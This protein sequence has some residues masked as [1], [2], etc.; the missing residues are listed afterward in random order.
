MAAEPPWTAQD[1]R[2]MT[3]ALE[4]AQSAYDIGEVPVGALVVSAQGDILGQGY[5]RTIIDH[6]PTAHAEIVA[7]RSAA[8]ALENYRL[9][10]ITVYVTLEPCVMCI[11]AMLH[12]L[13]LIHI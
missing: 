3:L 9:P 1:A 6:D 11:G 13:S 8:R 5:N 10:G 7:L 12:A 2:Y 4:L